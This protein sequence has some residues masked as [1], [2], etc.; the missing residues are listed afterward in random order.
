MSNLEKIQKGM[1][2]LLALSK[3]VLFMAIV[4][5][6]FTM[7]GAALVASGVVGMENWLGRFLETAAGI[8]RKQLTGTLLAS[9][10][11]F[12]F[13]GIFTAFLYHYFKEERKAG[14]PF[15]STGAVRIKK[16]GMLQVGLTVLNLVITDGIYEEIGL[17]EWNRYDD[18]GGIVLGIFL[19][20]LSTVFRYGAELEQRT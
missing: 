12:L 18:A 6:A 8:T 17:L 4:G 11:P 20:L 7:I 19:I 5:W 1:R 15:T 10:V 9:S 16:L 13:G 14:T 3:I 2:G